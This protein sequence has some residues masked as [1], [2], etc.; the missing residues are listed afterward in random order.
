[1]GIL[2][3]IFGKK[4]DEDLIGKIIKTLDLF[5]EA[6][7]LMV[8]LEEVKN[9]PEKRVIF[10]AYLY[11]SVDFTV[12]TKGF[13]DEMVVLI[14]G[15]FTK[16]LLNCTSEEFENFSKELEEFSQSEYGVKTTI[17]GGNTIKRWL[18]DKEKNAPIRLA[19][20]LAEL[21]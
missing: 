9:N 8:D 15:K 19:R 16:I 13:D 5:L 2:D 1:M 20:L 21:K 10:L 12:R 3:K 18:I 11:G 7:T 17:E 14:W 6:S 4:K